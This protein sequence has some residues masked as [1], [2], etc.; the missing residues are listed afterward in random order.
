MPITQDRLR[1]LLEEHERTLQ[2]IDARLN[3][4]DR[5]HANQSLTAADKFEM[6]HS[7]ITLLRSLSRTFAIV[8]RRWLN[9]NWKKNQ[10]SAAK[11]ERARRLAGVAPRGKPT[12]SD[13]LPHESYSGLA[14]S[15]DDYDR[16]DRDPAFAPSTAPASG[17]HVAPANSEYDIYACQYELGLADKPSEQQLAAWRTKRAQPEKRDLSDVFGTRSLEND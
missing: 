16:F 6:L 8:E 12:D 4:A 1:D 17:Q 10:R 11:Q 3:T 14:P 7:D 2:S 5:L 9:A 15:A 13:W